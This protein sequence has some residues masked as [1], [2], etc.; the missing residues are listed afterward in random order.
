MLM[1]R[2]LRSCPRYSTLKQAQYL[3]PHNIDKALHL[4]YI[5]IS[6]VPSHDDLSLSHVSILV[7]LLPSL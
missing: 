7:P 2:Q 1:L 5:V 4:N 6:I 3:A